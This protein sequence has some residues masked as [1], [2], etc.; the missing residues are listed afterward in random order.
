MLALTGPW[1]AQP[2][3]RRSVLGWHR[4]IGWF[5][6]PLLAVGPVSLVMM[7]MHG[8]VNVGSLG[9]PVT[10]ARVLERMAATGNDLG[11]LR[12]VQRLERGGAIVLLEP[13]PG[14]TRRYLVSAAT[15]TAL[16]TRTAR[17]GEAIH[18]GDWA[19]G[20]GGMLNLTSAVALLA[21]LGTGLVSW[22]RR[23]QAG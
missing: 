22:R 12:V 13:V 3:A 20:W 15:V 18:T 5:L 17:A 19:A 6:W 4:W 9:G 16:D 8:F 23:A 7:K 11:T 21:M 2:G 14:E 1:L 10:Y